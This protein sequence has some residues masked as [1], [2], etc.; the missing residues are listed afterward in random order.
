MVLLSLANQVVSAQNSSSS[1]FFEDFDGTLGRS[2]TG[3]ISSQD[4]YQE[5]YGHH[6][7]H[8]RQL[9]PQLRRASDRL[10]FTAGDSSLDNKYWIHQTAPAVPG[11]YSELLDPPQSKQDVTYWLNYLLHLQQQEA[12]TQGG[13]TDASN[14]SATAG[15]HIPRTAAINTAVEATT[16]NER[17]FRLRPQDAFIRDNLQAQ[18]ILVVSVGGNDVALT[19]LPCTVASI[20]SLVCCVP[21][22][23]I[24]RGHHCGVVPVDDC[25]L[26]CGPAL[27][28]CACSVPPCLGYMRH[29][30]W[31]RVQSYIA[32][33]TAKTKPALI[34]ACM[35]YYPDESIDPGWAGPALAALGYNSDPS[36]LQALI[37]K[38]FQEGTAKIQIPGSQVI[39]VPLFHVLDG[40][41]TDDYIQRVEPSASGGRK[42]AEFLLDLIN[43]GDAGGSLGP[44]IARAMSPCSDY[45]RERS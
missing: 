45:M 17:T 7:S 24:E 27:A 15:V 28:S 35:I 10:I 14:C 38:G 22:P 37:R 26:G 16:V 42:M 2:M 11:A 32:A 40:K 19:P 43:R 29:L 30:F 13:S 20:A 23:C 34:L 41:N 39:P 9:L 1:P 25:C 4:F 18:D 8:L 12:A 21:T 31:V 44:A 3:R 6:V 33:L 5:Y 36:K